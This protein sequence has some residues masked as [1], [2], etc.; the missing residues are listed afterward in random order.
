MSN[1]QGGGGA[2]GIP[3]LGLFLGKKFWGFRK[4]PIPRRKSE[5]GINN[6]N[7]QVGQ[8]CVVLHYGNAG[9]CNYSWKN[10]PGNS[11]LNTPIPPPLEH[12]KSSWSKFPKLFYNFQHLDS[13][14]TL[15]AVQVCQNLHLNAI[16]SDIN[17]YQKEHPGDFSISNVT[18][19][20]AVLI[21]LIILSGVLYKIFSWRKMSETWELKKGRNF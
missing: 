10:V 7:Q 2:P 5:S 16:N 3:G 9:N 20:L 6:F 18:L 19:P 8:E 1:Y 21:S 15:S 13:K 17:R 12:R 11:G 14:I 4:Q